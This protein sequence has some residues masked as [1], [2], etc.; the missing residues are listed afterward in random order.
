MAA[1]PAD[2]TLWTFRRIPYKYES[3][4]PYKDEVEEA[5]QK[6]S[7][8][9]KV[10]FVPHTNEYNYVFI[11][12][13]DTS[14]SGIGMENIGRQ[15]VNI[16]HGYKALHELGHT[17]GLI[18]EQCRDDRDQ[19]V[20]IEW[21]HIAHGQ[22]NINFILEPD[23]GNLT[24]YDTGSVMHYPAPATGW[25]G[26]PKGAE[27][28]T[29]KSI[30]DPEAHLGGGAAQGW[31]NM[32]EMDEMAIRELYKDV[33]VPMG[34]ETDNGPFKEGF[35]Q[36]CSYTIGNRTFFYAQNTDDGNWFIRELMP[37]GEMGGQTD[38][39]T[40]KLTFQNMLTFAIGGKT[41]LF[42][43]NEETKYHVIHELL[44]NGKLGAETT[45]KPWPV[46]YKSIVSY[47]IGGRV[48]LFGQY[49]GTGVWFI[50]EVLAGGVIGTQTATGS[51]KFFYDVLFTFSVGGKVYL[52]GQNMNE[53]NWFI[54]E[55]KADGTLGAETDND[56][57]NEAYQV[58]F[59]YNINGHQYMYGQSMDSHDWFIRQITRDGKMGEKLQIGTWKYG[60]AVQFPFQVG[61]QQ[62]FYGQN[63]GALNWFIQQLIDVYA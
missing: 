63:L 12:S 29:M 25:G 52:F 8:A 36:Q 57:W 46:Y 9:G 19:F 11:Q 60:Y 51:F 39:G 18:H 50:Q 4:F 38:F 56:V 20:D 2:V 40:T 31:T 34:P 43:Q 55:L 23:S 14:N 5:M 33:P 59:G 15:I 13:S 44:S 37:K 61:G 53:R 45:S 27:V 16:S 17:L 35:D 21:Y 30:K 24:Y 32:S 28:W 49:E 10:W 47:T 7:D 41:Y 62:Y 54:Q 6:W 1:T 26:F 58:Q 22:K 3:N 42:G 48:F